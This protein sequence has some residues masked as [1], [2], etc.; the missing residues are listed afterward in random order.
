[1]E[2]TS[3]NDDPLFANENE[4]TDKARWRAEES[5]EA[6]TMFQ[7]IDDEILKQQQQDDDDDFEITIAKQKKCDICGQDRVGGRC[8]HCFPNPIEA[9][10]QSKNTSHGADPFYDDWAATQIPVKDTDIVAEWRMLCID[11]GFDNAGIAWANCCSY[12]SGKVKMTFLKNKFSTAAM[13]P[14]DSVLN[15]DAH[16]DI[17]RLSSFFNNVFHDVPMNE[18]VVVVFESQYFRP[19]PAQMAFLSCR[20]YMLHHLANAEIHHLQQLGRNVIAFNEAS[21]AVSKYF[22]FQLKRYM[23]ENPAPDNKEKEKVY[24]NVRYAKKKKSI[25]CVTKLFNYTPNNDHEADAI[26]TGVYYARQIHP[27]L[28]VVFE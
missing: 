5:D 24:A 12:G 19:I 21:S 9:I 3:I 22:D 14:T 18:Q 10:Q 4:H 8:R 25:K 7:K 1:M 26:L 27:D 28:E 16:I 23:K 15:K 13:I 11:P 20:L 17:V 2:D 6:R